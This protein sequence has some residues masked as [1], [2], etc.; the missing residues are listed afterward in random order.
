MPINADAEREYVFRVTASDRY[1]IESHPSRP[2]YYYFSR[3][4]K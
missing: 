2:T 1:R 4:D 3:Y